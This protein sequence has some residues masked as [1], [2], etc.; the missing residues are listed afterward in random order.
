MNLFFAHFSY[1]RYNCVLLLENEPSYNII[2]LRGTNHDDTSTILT[3]S[4][5]YK[6]M[7][8]AIAHLQFNDVRIENVTI[9]QNRKI[10]GA[11]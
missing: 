11:R 6:H 5:L 2:T 4:R 3:I 7:V 9:L 8:L 1:N 10:E